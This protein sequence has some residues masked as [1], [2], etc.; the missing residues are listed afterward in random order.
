MPIK[1]MALLSSGITQGFAIWDGV[2]EWDPPGVEQADVTNSGYIKKGW[3]FH[4]RGGNSFNYNFVIDGNSL[5]LAEYYTPSQ[6][7]AARDGILTAA[8][9]PRATQYDLINMAHNGWATPDLAARAAN[10]I[11]LLYEASI[12]GKNV[13]VF[14][15]GTNEM[16]IFGASAATVYNSIKSYC[17]ARKAAGWKVIV[18]TLMPRHYSNAGTKD[19]FDLKR[20]DVNTMIRDAKTNGETWLDA[21]A[22]VGSD[23]IL[24]LASSFYVDSPYSYDGLHLTVTGAD[25]AKG[26]FKAAVESLSIGS[27][28]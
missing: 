20:R 5:A 1:K 26:Y 22:D 10:D 27:I 17:Q 8:I 2:T 4:D 12:L 16:H 19:V 28:E 13:L 21:I 25:I 11:D 24:G 6:T 23:A 14:W 18:G 7:R 9:S 3:P 15:E